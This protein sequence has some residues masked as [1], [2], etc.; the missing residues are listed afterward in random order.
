MKNRIFGKSIVFYLVLFILALLTEACQSKYRQPR[1]AITA[2][3]FGLSYYQGEGA[4]Q[5]YN[6]AF[7]WFQMASEKG[8]I[9]ANFYLGQM[10]YQGQGIRQHIATAIKY[11]DMASNKGHAGA[12]FM[13]GVI[14]IENGQVNIG[15][16]RLKNA[17]GKGYVDAQYKI[18]LI[19]FDGNLISKDYVKAFYW[20]EKAAQKNH[21]EA[22]Y[23]LGVMYANALGTEKNQ[24]KS[25][26]WMQKSADN[27]SEQAQN[28][29]KSKQGKN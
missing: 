14:N 12:L 11:F 19:L 20:F 13:L 8:S 17:A 18:G 9:E 2:Y 15:L 3:T 10:Y 5:D 26:S 1:Y 21:A 28:F 24:D 25:L 7:R 27:G 23:Y 4:D 29:L 6:E 22:Q 16:Q